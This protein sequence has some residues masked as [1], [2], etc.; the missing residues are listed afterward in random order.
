MHRSSAKLIMLITATAAACSFSFSFSPAP[1]SCL[2]QERDALFAFKKGIT[3][4]DESFLESWWEEEDCC[5]W[6]GVTCS[7]RTGNV[8]ELDLADAGLEGQ[9][10]PLLSLEQLEYIDLSINGLQGI[11]GSVP[12][13]LGSFINLRYLNLS[14]MYSFTGTLPPQLGNLSK[15]E[16][17]DLSHTG[18]L[19]GEVPPQLGNLSNMRYL[20]LKYPS[21]MYMI[22]GISWL[23][24]LHSLEY[25]DM[26]YVNLSMAV[27]WPYVFDTLPSLEALHLSHSSLPRM[28]L[29]M[30]ILNLTKF[31]ELDVSSNSFDH[32]IET[33]HVP[34][35]L[36]SLKNTRYLDLSGT[37][38]FSARV[39]PQL[40]NLTNLQHLDP[41]FMP[42]LN[43]TD[44]SWLTNLHM[45][46][47][48][49]MS[50]VNLRTVTDLALVVNMIPFLKVLIL[51]NCSLPSANQTLTQVNLTKL[52]NLDLSRN[53][54]GHSIASSWFWNVT[55][56][57]ILKLSETYL[58]GPFPDALGEMTSLQELQF[59]QN[60]NAATMMVDLRNLCELRTLYIDE[61]LSS[62][63]I[64]DFMDKL[65]RCPSSPL[66]VLSLR[67]NNMTGMLPNAMGHLNNLF[68]LD[69]SNNSISGAIPLGVQNL[70]GLYSLFLSSNRLTGHIPVLP[71]SLWSLDVSKNNLSG[72]LPSN[73]GSPNLGILILFNN[74]ITGQVPGSVC[75][76]NMFN[77]DIPTDITNLD[78]PQL[79]NL[80]GNN[81][82]GSIPWPLK[83]LSSMTL[84]LS[85]KTE[86][87]QYDVLTNNYLTTDIL[88]LITK[89]Q[90][91]KYGAVGS[92]RL[93]SI[94]LSLNH[95]TGEIPD[96]ITSLDGLMN[97][98]LS[99][100]HLR[101]KI[102]DNIGAMK[103]LQSLDLSRNN[104]FGEIPPSLSELTFLSTLDFSYNDLVGRIP[105]GHQLDTL[106]P[107]SPSM[108][109]GNSGLCGAPL[110]RN[111]SA[112]KLGSQN[113]SVNDS[114]PTMF[115]YLGLVTG[116]V[117]GLWVVFCAI[118]FKRSWRVAYFRQF[119]K[120]Y[121]I[122]YVFA[123]VTWA[124]LT[125]HA[126]AS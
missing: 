38:I 65:P 120:F 112:P 34:E 57:K 107:N 59:D 9:I 27:E 104:I 39:P 85:V 89:H 83:K 32:P 48:L 25:L 74:N 70:T 26:S 105:Q 58:D 55:S 100:N 81:I 116:F 56:I 52:E 88:S 15:L 43:S 37:S 111:C 1:A 22:T 110:Q 102:P 90:E 18:L 123:V 80:A 87:G 124:R 17:L 61:S 93:V 46:E 16:Y 114:E 68:A 122:A 51:N 78:K 66:T 76:H 14:Y 50:H 75:N 28:S 95:L 44:V 21:N 12:E 99:W 82:S 115:F 54:F 7:N 41:S 6:R 35:F 117:I 42:N 126:T 77:G 24:H 8:I 69:L 97:L 86:V 10:S 71:T 106:Y 109:D 101:G 53:Y 84:K 45:L 96:E 40:G 62:G 103:S 23:T 119:D 113:R 73:F 125:R 72:D 5:W 60:G 92:S 20:D 91:L 13:F 63:N 30:T 67:S 36:G 19:L 29:S 118:L 4:D 98:N 3:G 121:D 94:D 64:S 47:Y 108:Y 79:L 11:N 49:D 31:V 33:S 2:P